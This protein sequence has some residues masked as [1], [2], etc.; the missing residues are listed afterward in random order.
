MFIKVIAAFAI[1]I[2]G[3]FGFVAMQPSEMRI[4]RELLINA[5]PEVIFP[6]INNSKKTNEWMPWSES[7]P[8]VQMAYSGPE[9]GVGSL[10]S[11]DSK[12]Q[13]GTGKA[14]VIESIPNQLVKTQLTYTKPMEMSQLAE[15]SITPAGDASLVKWSV[16]GTNSFIGKLFSVIMN[17]DKVVGKD[18]EKGLNNLKSKTESSNTP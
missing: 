2:A 10:S 17:L 11:W 16:S 3:F 9:E 6:Y 14:E 7:D 15:I 12:G 1:F 13:M 4:S 5:K 18:F 8:G